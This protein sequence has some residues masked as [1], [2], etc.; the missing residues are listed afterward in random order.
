[1]FG[2]KTVPHCVKAVWNLWYRVVELINTLRINTPRIL[3]NC[4][5]LEMRVVQNTQLGSIQTPRWLKHRM[6][7]DCICLRTCMRKP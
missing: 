4:M 3:E 1:M 5:S 7:L 2:D 6:S